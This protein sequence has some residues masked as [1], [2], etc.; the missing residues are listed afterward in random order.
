MQYRTTLTLVFH[1]EIYSLL[2][3]IPSNKHGFQLGQEL[4]QLRE[5]TSDFPPE[6]KGLAIG[7]SDVIRNMHNSFRAPQPLLPD[8]DKDDSTGEA[9]HFVTYVPAAGGLYELD[10]LKPGPIRHCDCTTEEDWLY[11]AAEAVNQRIAKYA[12]SEVRFNLMALVRARPDVYEEQLKEA[13]K[14]VEN[15]QQAPKGKEGGDVSQSSGGG[16]INAAQARLSELEEMLVI[17]KEKRR[18]WSEENVRRR[19]DF[20]PLIFNLLKSLAA[21]GQLEGLVKKA[22]EETARKKAAQQQ[23]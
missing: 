4:T 16:D 22:E 12:A 23:R 7:N 19:T 21:A 3:N 6:M 14:V 10:G 5:F 18:R 17:E 1:N 2:M 9:F 15:L 20:T 8:E 13:R 11:R